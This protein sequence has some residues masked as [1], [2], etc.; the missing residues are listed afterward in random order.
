MATLL[1]E[2]K[3]DRY[4]ALA[5]QDVRPVGAVPATRGHAWLDERLATV[6]H[7]GAPGSLRSLQLDV[8]GIH[9]AA[10]VWLMNE[11]FRR[12]GGASITVN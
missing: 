5:G 11:T 4:Y 1:R 2:E 6:E 3:L 7:D 9:C 8:Q 10:C 12:A